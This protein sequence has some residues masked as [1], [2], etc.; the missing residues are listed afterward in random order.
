MDQLDMADEKNVTSKMT[1]LSGLLTFETAT[2][3]KD[4]LFCLG[5]EGDNDNKFS[6]E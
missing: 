6:L 3:R 2:L 4:L 5:W 1:Q